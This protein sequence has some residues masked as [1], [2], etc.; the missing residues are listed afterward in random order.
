MDRHSIINGVGTPVD[1]TSRTRLRLWRM[2]T[3]PILLNR[4]GFALIFGLCVLSAF[5][6]RASGLSVLN[7][8]TDQN[9]VISYDAVSVYNGPGTTVLRVLPPSNPAPGMPHRFIYVLPAIAGV[10]LQ[11]E[12]G[13]GLE[14]LRKLNVQNVYNAH[15]IA[16]SFQIVSWYANHASN[17]DR[18]YESFMVS[19][20]V[21]WVQGALSVTGQ[22]EHWLVGFSKSGFGAVT[23][24]FRNPSVFN[25]AAAWDFPADQ[26][27]TSDFNMLDNYGTENNF[28]SNYRLTSD[29][30]DAR[31][32]PFQGTGRLWLSQ[33]YVTY[34]GVPTYRDEV[35][36]FADRLRGEGAQFMLAGGA[37]RTHGW[38]SGWL[39]E[40]IAGL[41]SLPY[42]PV[43]DNFNRADGGLGSHWT[44]DPFWG[45][46]LS[47]SGNKVVAAIGN[48]GGS[49]WNGKVF[50][51]DQYSQIRLA[52][53]IG[54]W[55]G[56][57]VRASAS[58]TQCYVATIKSDGAYLY[59]LMSG[60]F[61]Q[62]VHDVT[63]WATGDILRLEVRTVGASTARLTVYRNGNQLFSYDDAS[64]F[65][66]GGQPGVGVNESTT[67]AVDDWESGNLDP[68]LSNQTAALSFSEGSGTATADN[69][70]SGH[71]GTLVNGP[72]WMAG[73]FGNGISFDGNNDYVSV[74]NPSDAQFWHERFYDCNLGQAAGNWGQTR[75][76]VQDGEQQLDYRGQG[77]LYRLEHEPVEF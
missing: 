3:S 26:P 37:A 72:T 42:L 20:L 45:S 51:G 2:V 28:Q 62:L 17:P 10:N 19:D 69:S 65:I 54:D 36:A 50:G 8:R 53:V 58:P 77:V 21:P 43:Q 38:A 61:F 25:A 29:W 9:G 74:A 63:G 59:S 32:G 68:A 52:G 48:A 57:M 67:V 15:I 7:P 1:K 55:S 60:T 30:I 39:P 76:P 14:E 13:D 40:A 64:H 23:L 35:L 73:R 71:T 47:I 11:D 34:F 44:A 75:H 56:V 6:D 5:A 27:D 24:L 4:R 49:Y 66:A 70:G 31:K 16:P 46:G 12:F 18:R 41:R 33:D 22:E